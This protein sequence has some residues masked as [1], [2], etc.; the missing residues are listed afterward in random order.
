MDRRAELERAARDLFG[1]PSLRPAAHRP[2]AGTIGGSTADDD[3]SR[4]R[5]PRDRTNGTVGGEIGEPRGRAYRGSA[6]VGRNLPHSSVSA[7]MLGI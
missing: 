7:R 6:A 5:L 4:S 2:A 1:W 3:R